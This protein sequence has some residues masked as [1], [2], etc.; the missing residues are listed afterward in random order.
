MESGKIV[1][2]ASELMAN[3]PNIRIKEG[4]AELA[5]K[6]VGTAKKSSDKISNAELYN[7]GKEITFTC[8]PFSSN[9]YLVLGLSVPPNKVK[10]FLD[11]DMIWTG[12]LEG[13]VIKIKDPNPVERM[14]RIVIFR[15]EKQLDGGGTFKIDTSVSEH[16]KFTTNKMNYNVKLKK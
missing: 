3:S 13:F 4:C 7:K 15:N 11:E 16:Y 2:T 14:L 5:A 6:L 8:E 1:K 10:V 12:G 9:L